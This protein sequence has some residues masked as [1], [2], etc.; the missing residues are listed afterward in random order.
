MIPTGPKGFAPPDPERSNSADTPY[1]AA[2][3]LII[4]AANLP[5]FFG[6]TYQDLGVF[7]GD[8]FIG[9]GLRLQP[10]GR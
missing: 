3:A 9:L 5:L 2:L 4:L 7:S 6:K 1:L 10:P 8:Y